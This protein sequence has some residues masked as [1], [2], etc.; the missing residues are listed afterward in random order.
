MVLLGIRTMSVNIYFENCPDSLNM[1]LSN[2]NFY[3]FFKALGIE[4][5][6]YC[7][8]VCSKIAYNLCKSFD[9]KKLVV[10]SY[11]EENIYYAGRTIE[12]VARYKWNLMK[13]AAEAKKQGKPI[14]WS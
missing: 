4:V 9:P 8:E 6:D 7:G 10:D 1:N 2:T 12:Q 5:N 3:R 14:L 13:L 11:Q